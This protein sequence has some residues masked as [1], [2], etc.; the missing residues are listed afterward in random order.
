MFTGIIQA[1]GTV[2]GREASTL[3][4]RAPAD[5][6]EDPLRVGESV[7]V[8]G[9]CLTLTSLNAGMTFDLSEETIL[10]TTLGRL[11][12]GDTVN[13]E[14]A[15]KA[16]D[17]M[18]GHIVQGHVDGV[19]ECL[20]I[21]DREDSK[22]FRFGTPEGYDRYLAD[23]CSIAIEGIS[24]TVVKPTAGAFDVWVVPHTFEHTNFKLMRP[25]QLVNMEFDIL[26][27][28][29]ERLMGRG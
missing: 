7:S 19:G 6:W 21:V 14:R 10:R 28:Y 25:D 3:I 11:Q 1:L 13:L 29:V 15:L 9:C 23:K 12:T 4:L 26:Y 18:G 8:N 16:S 17:R 5:S 20:N 24:L 27:K 2:T 22:V